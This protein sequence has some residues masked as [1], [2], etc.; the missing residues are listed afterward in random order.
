MKTNM[1]CDTVLIIFLGAFGLLGVGCEEPVDE[2]PAWCEQAGAD[3][4]QS[5]PSDGAD[6]D[7]DI[8][9]YQPT[10]EREHYNDDDEGSVT[11][12][13]CGTVDLIASYQDGWIASGCVLA[14][15]S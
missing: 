10:D 11:N 5:C 14:D 4:C 15:G 3:D 6:C 8:L 2:T 7:S 1:T 13:S 12:F 9:W